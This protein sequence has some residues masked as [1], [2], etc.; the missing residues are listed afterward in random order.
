MK[1][2]IYYYIQRVKE[3]NKIFEVRKALDSYLL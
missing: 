2:K 1:M 3:N